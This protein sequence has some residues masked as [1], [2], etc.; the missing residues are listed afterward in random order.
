MTY[1]YFLLPDTTLN[2]YYMIE[3]MRNKSIHYIL[4][5]NRPFLNI[6]VSDTAKYY[7]VDLNIL[8]NF[9]LQAQQIAIKYFDRTRPLRTRN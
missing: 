1:L 9:F 7:P 8:G 6:R 4:H 5:N 3:F 2:L